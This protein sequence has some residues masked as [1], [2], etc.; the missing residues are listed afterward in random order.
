MPK[1]ERPE[2]TRQENVNP[3]LIDKQSHPREIERNRKKSPREEEENPQQ[4]KK[5]DTRTS[6][7]PKEKQTTM[8]HE[9]STSNT[10]QENDRP[11]E[12]KG[13][14]EGETAKKKSRRENSN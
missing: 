1:S 9:D 5:I 14:T 11:E 2:T 10:T 3:R 8:A 13:I 4:Q 6:G 12:T 7:N